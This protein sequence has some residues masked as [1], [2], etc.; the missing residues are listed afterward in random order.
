MASVVINQN[1]PKISLLHTG[2]NPAVTTFNAWYI[3][4]SISKNRTEV[5]ATKNSLFTGS[6][7]FE[8]L[9][10]AGLQLFVLSPAY[11]LLKLNL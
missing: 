11:Y 2:P 6:Y 10:Y 5:I 9:F 1:I 7:R 4:R 8:H 3:Y